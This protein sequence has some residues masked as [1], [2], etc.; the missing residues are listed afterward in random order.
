VR[1]TPH[2]SFPHPDDLTPDER[3]RE[4][5]AIL[6]AGLT[7]LRART[8]PITTSAPQNLPESETIRDSGLAVSADP[9]LHGAT[10]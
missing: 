5:A 10:G 4:L 9:W 3:R 6:A 7:R 8:A 2:P 1:L